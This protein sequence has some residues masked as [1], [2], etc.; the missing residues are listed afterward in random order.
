M[1]P[2]VSLLCPCAAVCFDESKEVQRAGVVVIIE[3]LISRCTS[4]HTLLHP[5]A[6]LCLFADM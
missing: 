6:V 3:A 4:T 2:S 1:V 5:D